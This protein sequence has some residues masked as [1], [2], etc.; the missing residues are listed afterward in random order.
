MI[1]ES[2]V[3]YPRFSSEKNSDKSSL[4]CNLLWRPCVLSWQFPGRLRW[5]RSSSLNRAKQGLAGR[6]GCGEL[7]VAEDLVKGELKKGLPRASQRRENHMV[8]SRVMQLIVS[9]NVLQGNKQVFNKAQYLTVAWFLF[10]CHKLT[11]YLLKFYGKGKSQAFWY[12][13]LVVL[14]T[15][16]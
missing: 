3:V 16:F 14:A 2:D 11:S 12:W 4:S 8:L 13:I 15:S 6:P 10:P 9:S 1:N 7:D 5:Q